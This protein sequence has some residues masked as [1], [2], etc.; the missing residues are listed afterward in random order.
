MN[1]RNYQF[2]EP[3]KSNPRK[4]QLR[5]CRLCGKVIQAGLKV[6]AKG[7]FCGDCEANQGDFATVT[8]PLGNR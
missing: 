4:P 8:Q 5:R 7:R 1:G 2:K 6:Y 3:R